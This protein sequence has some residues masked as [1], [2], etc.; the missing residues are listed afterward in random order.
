MVIVVKG[1]NIPI[2]VPVAQHNEICLW[3]WKELGGNDSPPVSDLGLEGDDPIN[4]VGLEE[5]GEE[6]G[7]PG[8]DMFL[9][10]AVC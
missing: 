4:D 6:E 10:M 1:E 3:W 7:E 8:G 2:P 5:G 9:P